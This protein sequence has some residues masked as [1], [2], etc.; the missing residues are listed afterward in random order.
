MNGSSGGVTLLVLNIDRTSEASLKVPA[1][2]ERYTLSSPDL[3]SKTVLLNGTELRAGADGT[4]PSMQG[5]P[6][7]AGAITFAPLTITFLTMP[8]AGNPQCGR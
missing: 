4:V 7:K 6:S 1:A 3:F 2:G 8:S 5:Q